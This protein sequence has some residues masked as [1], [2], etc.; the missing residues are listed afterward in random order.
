MEE[1]GKLLPSIFKNQFRREDARVVEV[2][3]P[4]WA[5]VAGRSIAEHSRPLTFV[6]GTLTLATTCPTWAAQLRQ[7]TEEIRGEINRFLG[8]LVVKKLRVQLVSSVPKWESQW[9][10]RNRNYLASRR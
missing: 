1:I 4:L 2:L 10:E 9:D 6:T 5:R 8:C 3:G 7:M